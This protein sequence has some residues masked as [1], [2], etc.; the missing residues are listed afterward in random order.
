[1]KD[2]FTG[3]YTHF[4]TT[5]HSSFYN[6]VGGRL[7]LEEAPASTPYPYATYSLVVNSYDASFTSHFEEATIDFELYSDSTGGATQITQMYEK[8]KSQF[9]D[10]S[11][12]M[13]SSYRLVRFRRERAELMRLID[14]IP[15]KPV[16][17]YA[18]TY[19]V[20]TRKA[21]T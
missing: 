20:L 3:I 19:S 15:N 7:F 12:V 9:D 5:P 11:F 1:M 8:L 6:A 14:Q 18:V 17:H 10:P 2:L 16:W 4:A 13:G 21:R